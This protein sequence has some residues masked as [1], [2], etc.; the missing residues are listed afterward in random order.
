MNGPAT[1][2]RRPAPRRAA[3]AA[4]WRAAAALAAAGLAL[5]PLGWLAA[6][7]PE[8]APRAGPERVDDRTALRDGNR[9]LRAGDPEAAIA[10]WE[11]GWRGGG[12][13]EQA[14]L[15]YNLA[16]TAHRLGRRPEAVLWYRRAEAAGGGD[17]WLAENLALARA[18]LDAPRL[19]PAGALGWLAA[20]PAVLPA[21]AAGLSWLAAGLLAAALLRGGR[22]DTASGPSP[23][24]APGAPAVR[25]RRAGLAFG[26]AALAAWAAGAAV[27]SGAPRPAVLTAACPAADGELAAGS[28]VWVRRSEDGGGW[29]IAAAAPATLCPPGAVGLVE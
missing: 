26:T 13:G 29:R 12:S 8:P 20:R 23:S 15:A 4:R 21:L 3:G 27:A 11:A 19:P 24:P 14:A 28:E 7:H 6:R 10:A 16:T 22:R 1:G 5:A 17:A 25:L 2:A 18:E 9:R